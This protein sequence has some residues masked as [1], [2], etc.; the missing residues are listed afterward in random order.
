MFGHEVPEL[1]FPGVVLPGI[2]FTALCLWP[3]IEAGSPGTAEPHDL[4]QYPR[5]LPWRTALGAAMLTF[6]VAADR[7][8]RRRRA[9]AHPSECRSRRMVRVLRV[10]VIVVPILVFAGAY[11]VASGLKRSGLHPVKRSTIVEVRRRPDG[12]FEVEEQTG[13]GFPSVEERLVDDADEE[14]GEPKVGV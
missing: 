4:L 10:V 14:L 12:G 6:F 3:W 8:R 5:D 9:G 13:G 1:F 7:G 2:V 11:R